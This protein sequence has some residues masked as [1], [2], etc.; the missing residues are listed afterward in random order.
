MNKFK[1]FFADFKKFISRGNII[2][3][4][5]GVIVGSAFSAIV[6]ALT[7]KIIMPLINAMLAG[8]KGLENAYTMLVPAYSDEAKTVI[9]YASSIYIDWGAFIT[10]ILNF[11]IIAFTLFIV[12]RVA[13]KGREMFTEV[14]KQMKPKLTCEQVKELKARGVKLT[15]KKAV[16]EYLAEVAAKAA[17]EKAKAE[18]EAKAKA[19]AEKLAHPTQEELLKQ[20]RDLLAEKKD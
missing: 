1:Q 15:D 2:D 10:A 16:A 7:N 6:T 4:A 14:T 17:E 19:E 8:G 11:L 9:D 3:M 18:E 13:M 12:L 20:I 5:V